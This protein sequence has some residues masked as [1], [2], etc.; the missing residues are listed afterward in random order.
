MSSTDSRTDLEPLAELIDVGQM[1]GRIVDRV[2]RDPVNIDDLSAYDDRRFP[3]GFGQLAE[4]VVEL[5]RL[6]L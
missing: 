3:G 4:L 2:P 1:M 5:A 6:L